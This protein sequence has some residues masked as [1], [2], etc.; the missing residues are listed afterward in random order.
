[1]HV[2]IC[3]LFTPGQPLEEA[4]LRY[5]VSFK[6]KKNIILIYNFKI[7]EATDIAMHIEF[8]VVY[9]AYLYLGFFKF[10]I[11]IIVEPTL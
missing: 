2:C 1:M 8:Y 6:K 4:Q 7:Q 9:L 11:G 10:R 3:L 5:L